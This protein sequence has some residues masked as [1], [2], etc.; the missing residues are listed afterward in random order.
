MIQ[1][2]FFKVGKIIASLS[3]VGTVPAL[4]DRLITLAIIGASSW[5]MHL[6]NLAGIGLVGKP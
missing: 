3:E 4:I 6:N 5:Y 1:L 2:G